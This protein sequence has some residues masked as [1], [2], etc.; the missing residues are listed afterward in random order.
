MKSSELIYTKIEEIDPGY[1]ASFNLSLNFSQLSV[2]MKAVPFLLAGAGFSNAQPIFQHFVPGKD[3]RDVTFKIINVGAG[4]KLF[5]SK[6]VAL[7]LEYRFQKFNAGEK[8][9]GFDDWRYTEKIGSTMHHVYWGIS[10][11]F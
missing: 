10:A 7:R 1:V 8:E 2:E 11:F 5:L 4:L 3:W 9:I 6:S